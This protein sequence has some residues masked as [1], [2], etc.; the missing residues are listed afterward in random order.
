MRAGNDAAVT[1]RDALKTHRRN[2]PVSPPGFLGDVL[3]FDLRRVSV[4]LLFLFLYQV[5]FFFFLNENKKGSVSPEIK[6][7]VLL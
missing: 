7:V 2:N 5:F 3:G 1:R 6:R 4:M